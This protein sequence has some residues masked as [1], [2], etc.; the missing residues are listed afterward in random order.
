MTSSRRRFLGGLAAASVAA[1]F[2]FRNASAEGLAKIVYQTSWTPEPD[3]GGLYQAISTGIYKQFGLDVEL[4]AGGPQLNSS[5]IFFAGQADFVSSDSFRTLE[6]VQRGLPGI[7]VAAFYQK[8]PTIL[9]SHKHVGNDT[10][11]ELKNKPI[12]ISTGGREAY[13]IWLKAKYGYSD[14]QARPYTFTM[15]PFLVEP[16][17]TMEGYVTI[18]PFQAH[19]AGVDPVVHSLADNGYQAYYNVILASPR[20]IAEKRDLVARFV[21]AT[22]KGWHDFLYGNAKPALQAIMNGNP[23]MSPE[24]VGYAHNAMKTRALC[25]SDDVKRFGVGAMTDAKWQAI[26]QSLAAVGAQPRGIDVR[27]GYT[28]QFTNKP[29]GVL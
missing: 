22:R 7:A 19:K 25:E 24:L 6:Y 16:D 13:W 20:M 9:L 10:L 1:P 17:L 2:V 8:P 14:D 18:E 27:K 28:L 15:A 23:E 26:Y 4:H 21:A 29:I 12:L 5:Q 3:D 11:A